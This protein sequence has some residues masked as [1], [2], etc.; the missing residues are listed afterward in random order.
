MRRK[1]EKN[2][3]EESE[4]RHNTHTLS[5]VSD[6]NENVYKAKMGEREKAMRGKR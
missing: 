2:V 4:N 6:G 5:R 3:R 1:G